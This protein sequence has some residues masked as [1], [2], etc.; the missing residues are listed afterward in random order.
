[1]HL[2]AMQIISLKLFQEVLHGVV[3]YENKKELLLQDKHSHHAWIEHNHLHIRFKLYIHNIRTTSCSYKF[4]WLSTKSASCIWNPNSH[5]K[6]H[7]IQ[8]YEWQHARL[9]KQ[10][11]GKWEQGGGGRALCKPGTLLLLAGQKGGGVSKGGG[12]ALAEEA[13]GLGEMTWKT[14]VTST[15]IKW[16]S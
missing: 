15:Y 8:L 6:I 12:G 1:M 10:S 3:V 13:M 9:V 11:G 16:I 2:K 5:S 4:G 14:L 7:R